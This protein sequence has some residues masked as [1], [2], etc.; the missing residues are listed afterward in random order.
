VATMAIDNAYNGGLMAARIVGTQS[1]KTATAL[2]KYQK[3]LQVK[4][5][6]MNHNL[7]ELLKD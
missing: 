5:Q 7:Q 2:K 3:S 1:K 6:N 4:V